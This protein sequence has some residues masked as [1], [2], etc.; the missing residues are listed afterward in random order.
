MTSRAT[1]GGGGSLKDRA[2]RDRIATRL[3]INML[4]EAGAGSG[5]THMLAVRMAAGIASGDYRIEHM[6]A[7]TFTRKAAAELRGRFQLALEDRLSN[8]SRDTSDPE[9]P[10]RIAHALGNLERFF[11]GTI[12]SF[13]ARLLRERPIE[14]GLAPG[15][16]EMDDVQMVVRRRQSWRD[17]RTEARAADDPDVRALVEEGIE[18]SD[19]DDAFAKICMH[20]DVDFPAGKAPRPAPEGEWA[21]ARRFFDE[22]TKKLGKRNIGWDTT[23]PTQKAMRQHRGLVRVAGTDSPSARAVAQLLAVWDFDPEITQNRWADDTATKKRLKNEIT[24]LHADFRA[25]VVEPYLRAWRQYVYRLT[26]PVLLHARERYRRD[27]L[28]DSTLDYGD[29]LQITARLLRD[30][31]EVRDALRQKYRWIFVDEFQDTDPIQADIL[32]LLAGGT[33]FVVGDPKQSI[34]RFTRADIDTYNDVRARFEAGLGEVVSLTTNFRSVPALCAWANDV[35]R[36]RFPATPTAYSP[37]FAPLDPVPLGLRSSESKIARAVASRAPSVCKLTVPVSVT[38]KHDVA[39]DE[40]S[41]IARYIRAEVD[42]GRRAFGDF[43]ILARRKGG[44]L[45]P[46]TQALEALQIPIEVSGAGAFGESEEVRTLALLLRALADPQDGV[47]L[48]GVLRGPLFGFSDRDLFDYRHADGR[49]SIF[50]TSTHPVGAALGLLRE[51]HGWTR[52]L[53][54]GAALE[55]MLERTGYLALAATTPGGVEAG[56]LLH[57]LGR[58]RAVVESGGSLLDAADALDEDAEESTD[59]ESLPLEPGQPNVVRLMNLHKAKGLEADV[60]FLAD[61]FGTYPPRADIR[62]VRKADGPAMGYLLITKKRGEHGHELVAEPVGWDAHEAEELRYLEA[63]RERLLYVAATR[64]RELCAVGRWAKPGDPGSAWAPL[65]DYLGSAPELPV[66][67]TA[68]APP[69]GKVNLSLAVEAKAARARDAAHAHARQASW[70]A[71]SVTGETKLVSRIVAVSDAGAATAHD[72][73]GVVIADTP[74][75]RAD[76]G[77]AWGTLVHGLLEH[78]M[79]H[80]SATREDLR[81]LAMWLTIEEL[82]L[83]TVID[84][85]LD[86]VE[87]VKRADFWQAARASSEVHEEAPFGVLETKDGLPQV[88]GGVIDLV[89]RIDDGWRIV[90]Y[91]TDTSIVETDLVARYQAQLRAYESAWRRLS[92]EEVNT[93]VI[94]ARVE[95]RES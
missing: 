44:R 46:Y 74:T 6:A 85:A 8:W 41:R 67:A 57:A 33:L 18:P 61:P 40:A 88:V 12:H 60:V 48:V 29:L 45:T 55:R 81:R 87:T 84:Q 27:R 42:A 86:T 7:V 56:D 24:T 58:V 17:Y 50:A 49:F 73:G 52:V 70:S 59:V 77:M 3:H 43:L 34:Y 15:F 78:A 94:S 32:F 36:H 65:E 75:R 91:K 1:T 16:T 39:A 47:S 63:E 64:A 89:Y 19:L 9:E 2:A 20:E 54:A 14:A 22:L 76:A 26:V 79:R 35:F 10:A 28:R 37:R 93:T 5:K 11:A 30:H 31:P 13:C 72:P 82:E 53:P 80:K 66:P 68:S 90:D 38:R 83:R 4:V 95:A 21:A 92:D 69:D 51:M 23:C 62:I 25:R 71:T